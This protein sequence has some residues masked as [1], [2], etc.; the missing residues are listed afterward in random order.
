MPIQARR[1]WSDFLELTP[2]VIS[3]GFDDG[4][5]RQVYFGHATEHFAHVIQLEGMIASNYHDAQVTYVAM[6]TDIVSDMQVKTGGVD[7]SS[8]MGVGMVMNVLTK[9]GGNR[10]SGNGGYAYQPF[11]WNGNNVGE[12]HDVRDLQQEHR[13]ARR[14]PR[15]CGSST[16]SLGGPM[17][18]RRGVVLRL[19]AAGRV[20]EPASAARR[21]RWTGCARSSR[22][23]RCSTTRARAGSRTSRSSGKLAP[24]HDASALLSA[25]PAASS[26][27]NR[28]YNYEQIQ[29]Q[30]TGG[31]LYGGKLTSVWGDRVTTTFVGSYN[32]KG[33][34]DIS[35]F[36]SLGLSGPQ[37][38]LHERATVGSG[39]AVGSGR[40]LE[41]GNL[42]SYSFQPASQIMLRGDLTYFKRRVARQPRVPDR[43]LHGAAEHLRPGHRV[44][45]R[46]LRAR[47]AAAGGR[48]QPGGRHRAVPP[49]SIARRSR[50]RRGPAVDR[51]RRLLRA[52]QLAAGQPSDLNAGVRFDWVKRERQ[53]LRHRRGRT[54]GRWGRGFGFSLHADRR[55]QEHPA[56]QLRA[57]HEQMMGRDA[58]TTFGADGAAGDTGTS[59]IWMAT[60]RSRRRRPRLAARTATTGRLRVRPEPAPAVRRR[61]HPRLPQAV[62]RAVE[63]RRVVD[64][65][66]LPGHVRPR[67][68][69]RHLSERARTSRSAASALVDPNRGIVFQQTNNSWSTLE[70]QALWN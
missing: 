60:A 46:R 37:I 66:Q 9:S 8:P 49:S 10:F 16:A 47:G 64:E 11:N 56:R 65:A 21:S 29:A 13:R 41:G 4:S 51:E 62:P 18:A 26:T 59:T 5:G 33:G 38:I 2:G 55:R 6:G 25:R 28:E 53:H 36:E 68:H 17:Q 67:R 7:A 32:N 30:S 23:R 61:V 52:G 50:C 48:G 1:N 40:I 20:G 14:R 42:Q 24:N 39:R 45:Q 44:R 58:V 69:Q 54:L 27:G 35:T 43:V 3:R 31:S 15:T 12:L 19:A 22:A 57:L 63:R 70:W 34:N